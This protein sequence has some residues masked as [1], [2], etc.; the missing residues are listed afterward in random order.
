MSPPR[1]K[2]VPDRCG[3]PDSSPGS[4]WTCE[5]VWLPDGSGL[6]AIADSAQ[7]DEHVHGRADWR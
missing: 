4:A 5:A 3:A 6:L 7:R 1:D 2:V